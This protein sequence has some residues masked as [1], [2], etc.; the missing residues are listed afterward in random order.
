MYS[1]LL[2]LM[3]P[4]RQAEY[5]KTKYKNHRSTEDGV[6]LDQAR[7]RE[8]KKKN[9]AKV[10]DLNERRR[11]LKRAATLVSPQECADKIEELRRECFCRWCCIR[12]TPSNRS[13]DHIIPLA[14]GGAHI[15]D[16]LAAACRTC[17]SS[18]NDKFLHEW[19]WELAA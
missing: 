14:R 18:K 6:A 13:I 1:Q 15:P 12:L 17:N 8:W 5:N 9:P 19:E 3:Y 4:D 7:N 11:H 10:R 16:N 2:N